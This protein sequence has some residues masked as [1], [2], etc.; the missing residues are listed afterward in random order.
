M[1]D[2]PHANVPTTANTVSKIQRHGERR[3]G[4]NDGFTVTGTL[5]GRSKP[6]IQGNYRMPREVLEAAPQFIFLA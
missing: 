2:D 3:G 6:P 4:F 1:S 5:G